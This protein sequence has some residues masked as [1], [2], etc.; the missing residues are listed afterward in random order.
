ME[1][2]SNKYYD[3]KIIRQRKLDWDKIKDIKIKDN[4]EKLVS[5]SLIPEK[6]VVR[7]YYYIQKIKGSM[8]ECYVRNSVLDKLLKAANKLPKGYKLVIFDAWRPI[9]VQAELYKMIIEKLKNVYPAKN[10]A[11]IKEE[12]S[13]Y[14]A[15]PSKNEGCPSPHNTGGSVDLSIADKKGKLLNMGTTFDTAN[16][17]SHTDYFENKFSIKNKSNEMIKEIVLNRRL[18]YNIMTSVGFTN[19]PKEWWHYDYGNQNWAYFNNNEVTA[20]YGKTSP[21]FIWNNGFPLE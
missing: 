1:A 10:M 7:P 4:N 9:E 14:V 11:E 19:Y 21:D 18:L 5:T 16:E 8:P 12:A 20:I 15:I 6:I 17:K 3:N 13:N 2:I